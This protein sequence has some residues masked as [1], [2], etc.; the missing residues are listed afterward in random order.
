MMDQNFYENTHTEESNVFR[1]M[2]WGMLLSAPIWLS[3]FGWLN[4][5]F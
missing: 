1:G 2:A 3:L 4:L 5:I